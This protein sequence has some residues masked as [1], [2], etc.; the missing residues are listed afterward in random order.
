MVEAI[1]SWTTE[2]TGW[3]VI[4][5][6]LCFIGIALAA[7]GSGIARGERKVDER[8]KDL[9]I[10]VDSAENLITIHEPEEDKIFAQLTWDDEF[11][12]LTPYDTDD[13]AWQSED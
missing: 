10:V 5:I 13:Q 12:T 6:W 8:L 2:V 1:Q 7:Y 11:I 4:L 9:G 3:E